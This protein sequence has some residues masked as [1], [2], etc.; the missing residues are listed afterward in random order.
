M[1]TFTFI[2]HLFPLRAKLYY[3]GATKKYY[4]REGT[5]FRECDKTGITGHKPGR[6]SL[7]TEGP[8]YARV[9]LIHTKMKTF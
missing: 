6:A 8:T 1:N 9:S 5:D 2:K 4:R 7:L 3:D